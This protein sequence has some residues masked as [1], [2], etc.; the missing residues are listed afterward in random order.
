MAIEL[1]PEEKIHIRKIL[2]H[3]KDKKM[4]FCYDEKGFFFDIETCEKLLNIK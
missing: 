2:K 1:S 4:G 3:L